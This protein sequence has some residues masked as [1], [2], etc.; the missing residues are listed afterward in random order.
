MKANIP[1]I[2]RIVQQHELDDVQVKTPDQKYLIDQADSTDGA[3][4]MLQ[5][6]DGNIQGTVYI[7]GKKV[8][9]KG[10]VYRW[11]CG[12]L[13]HNQGEPK[14]MQGATESPCTMGEYIDLRLKL[15]RLENQGNSGPLDRIAGIVETFIQSNAGAKKETTNGHGSDVQTDPEDEE[16]LM[17][18]LRFKQQHPEQAATYIS[19]MRNMLNDEQ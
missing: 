2:I 10:K 8:G 1:T 11:L 15:D 16:I 17:D 13:D 4:Q 7:Y 14:V 12:D 19:L 3:V 6:L 18:V 9:T 5:E